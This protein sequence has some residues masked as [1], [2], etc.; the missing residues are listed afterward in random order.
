MENMKIYRHTD[1]RWNL[2][3]SLEK[4]GK[5]TESGTVEFKGQFWGNRNNPNEPSNDIGEIIDART[6]VVQTTALLGILRIFT[7]FLTTEDTVIRSLVKLQL[8]LKTRKE[9]K[10]SQNKDKHNQY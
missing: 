9:S 6:G 10:N 4:Y 2:Y 5:E 8:D 1:R 3:N 7:E